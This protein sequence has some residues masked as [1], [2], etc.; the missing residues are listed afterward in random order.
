MGDLRCQLLLYG[1]LIGVLQFQPDK[2]SSKVYFFSFFSIFNFR[3]A[4]LVTF[5]RDGSG[6]RMHFHHRFFQLVLICPPMDSVSSIVFVL[7]HLTLHAYVSWEQTFCS[8]NHFH[9]IHGRIHLKNFAT[10]ALGRPVHLSGP[11]LKFC[12]NHSLSLNIPQP[13][14]LVP[15]AS[16]KSIK[17]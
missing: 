4:A 8:S 6:G 17:F 12:N 2:F 15:R 1:S 10:V 9:I 14:H 16:D 7:S 3:Q 13:A 5:S 11:V